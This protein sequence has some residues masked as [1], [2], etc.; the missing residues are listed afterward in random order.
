MEKK[1]KSCG[2]KKSMGGERKLDKIGKDYI[3]SECFEW[4]RF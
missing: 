4:G 1:C 3:C 2:Y